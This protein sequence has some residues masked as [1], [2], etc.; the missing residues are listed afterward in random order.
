MHKLSYCRPVPDFGQGICMY[1]YLN[2]IYVYT[3]NL[4]LAQKNR[5]ILNLL[6]TSGVSL[7]RDDKR[8]NLGTGILNYFIQIL[9]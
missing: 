5:S 4:N 2:L 8:N 9:H 6:G 1:F 7:E 3:I